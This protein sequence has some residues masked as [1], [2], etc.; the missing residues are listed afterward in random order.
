MNKNMIN[1]KGNGPSQDLPPRL[2]NA[3]PALFVVIVLTP[4]TGAWLLASFGVLLTVPLF[5]LPPTD[6]PYRLR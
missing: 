5:E 4:S 2:P 1:I 3:A 6:M